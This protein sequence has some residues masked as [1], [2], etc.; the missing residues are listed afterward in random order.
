MIYEK[1]TN[2][3]IITVFFIGVLRDNTKAYVTS[4]GYYYEI[5]D[6]EYGVIDAPNK[7]VLKY[8]IKCYR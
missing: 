1:G 4:D 8:E 6:D 7:L 2:R 3:Q 5:D